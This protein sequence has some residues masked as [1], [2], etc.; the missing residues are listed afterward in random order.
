M[1]GSFQTIPDVSTLVQTSGNQNI[2]GIKTFTNTTTSSSITNGAVV[3]GGGLGIG[4]A[5]NAGIGSSTHTLNGI[6]N[7]PTSNVTHFIYGSINCAV[8][9]STCAI[10]GT[11]NLSGITTHIIAGNV[12]FNNNAVT[13]IIAGNLSVG[14]I[15]TTAGRKKARRSVAA[16][17][18]TT[19][20]DEVLFVDASGGSRTITLLAAA[21]AGD[22]AIITIYRSDTNVLA[23]VTVTPVVNGGSIGIQSSKTYMSDATNW[24]NIQ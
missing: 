2:S 12:N 15:L 1:S 17:A 11:L 16:N 13:Q 20:T 6:L 3:I 24:H 23:S 21:T 19:A 8:T 10:A 4:G 14:K 18:A 5:I 7:L 9:S 22:G